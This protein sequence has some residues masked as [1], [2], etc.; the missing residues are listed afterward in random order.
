MRGPK[1]NANVANA[2]RKG[3]T[4][5]KT[6]LDTMSNSDPTSPPIVVKATILRSHILSKPAISLLKPNAPPR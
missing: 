5:E 4:S 1:A 2:S 3:M 6:S